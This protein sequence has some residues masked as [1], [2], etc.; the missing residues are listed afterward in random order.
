MTD[1]ATTIV[2][3]EKKAA[4][5]SSTFDTATIEFAKGADAFDAYAVMVP[6]VCGGTEDEFRTAFADFRAAAERGISLKSI[7]KDLAAFKVTKS[8][9]KELAKGHAHITKFTITEE[10]DDDGKI[11]TPGFTPKLTY[12]LEY[13]PEVEEVKNDKDEIT[14]EAVA[15]SAIIKVIAGK[16]STRSVGKGEKKG[17]VSAFVAWEKT[18]KKQGD[19]FVILKTKGSDGKVDGYKVDGRFVGKGKLTKF[20][21]DVHPNSK[22]IA[23][24]R[25][26]P[27]MKIGG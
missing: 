21:L 18:G 11:T 1:E 15:A 17:R 22:T 5:F 6:K 7:E 3:V 24:M 20:L 10:K 19:T 12:V 9:I 13:I 2:E 8:I 16:V 25:S 4:D 27:E 14:T 23:H 26:Y